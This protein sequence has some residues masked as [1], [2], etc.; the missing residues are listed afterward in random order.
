MPHLFHRSSDSELSNSHSAVP[1]R[2]PKCMWIVATLMSLALIFG[3]ASLPTFAATGSPT[4]KVVPKNVGIPGDGINCSGPHSGAFT[5]VCHV[6]L[7]ET[8]SSSKPLHWFTRSDRP[9]RFTP[10]NGYLSPGQSVRVIIATNF[11]GGFTNF[12]FVGSKNVATVTYQC[13]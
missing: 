11:C 2:F 9:A 6:T 5:W 3:T 10:A 1:G 7:T 12:Y 4:L 8:V 13:G